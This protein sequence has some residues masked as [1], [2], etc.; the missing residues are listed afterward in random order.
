MRYDRRTSNAKLKAK[1]HSESLIAT[2]D[3]KPL[4]LTSVYDRLRALRN[5]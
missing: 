4:I 2:T 3:A 1:K 5:L